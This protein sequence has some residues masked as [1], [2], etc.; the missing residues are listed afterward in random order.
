VPIVQKKLVILIAGNR[1]SQLLQ[2]PIGSRMFG[3]IEMEE[4][5]RPDLQSSEYI[6]P[7]RMLPVCCLLDTEANLSHQSDGIGRIVWHSVLES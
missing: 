6:E 4:S 5:P 2:N 1:L 3:H 7:Y